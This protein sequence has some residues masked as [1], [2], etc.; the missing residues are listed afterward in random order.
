MRTGILII[1]ALA[2]TCGAAC[3]APAQGQQPIAAPSPGRAVELPVTLAGTQILVDGVRVNGRGPFRFLL[4]TGAQGAGR[5]D[6]TLVQ[7]LDLPQVGVA[8]VA[9]GGGGPRRQLP[10]H[11]AE[12]L[13]IGGLTFSDLDLVSRDYNAGGAGGRGPIAGVLGIDLFRGMLL[14]IDY[15]RSV[16]RLEPGGLPDVD[17]RSILAL[18][19][20]DPV[21]TVEIQIGGRSLKAHIDTGAMG[22]VT[23]GEAFAQT[24]SF[25]APPVVVGQARTVS[26]AFE[27]REARLEGDLRLGAEVLPN[28]TIGIVPRFEVGNLGGSF[29]RAYAMTLDLA[30]HRVRFSPTTGT[31]PPPP[32]RYGL[33]M[34]PPSGGETG[35]PLRGVA[36]G[37]PA[38][39]GGLRAGDV[40]V[41]LN[42]VPVAELGDRLPGF[43]RAS[44]LVVGFLRDGESREITLSLD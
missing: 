41:S 18:D 21:P 11:K 30:N 8:D 35:L 39:T 9:D 6:V 33:M 15:G 37:S 13:E 36:P 24:L 17:G 19:P 2:L 4:D 32:R 3:A 5:A 29:L 27:V 42:G 23:V 40:V 31:P 20:S 38:E 43:M 28:P 12:S 26:G 44:P 1:S 22:G 7:T 10:V 34:T 16:L 14:T 25:T